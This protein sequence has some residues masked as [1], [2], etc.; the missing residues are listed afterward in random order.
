MGQSG[1]TPSKHPYA[2]RSQIVSPRL[3]DDVL[4]YIGPSLQKYK[5]CDILDLNPGAGLWSE[6]LHQFLKPRSHVLL[7]PLPE[8]F[9]EYLEPLVKKPGSKFRLV[10][11]DAS[12]FDGLEQ[13]LREGL[14]PHQNPLPAG[15]VPS[16]EP[17]TTLLVTGTIVWNPKHPGLNFFSMAGQM[18]HHFIRTSWVNEG[19]HVCGPVR[20]LLWVPSDDTKFA[21]NK[22]AMA[23]SRTSA[24]V[25]KVAAVS[26]VVK[27]GHAQDDRHWV[28]EAR[29]E[30]E[31]LVRAM[32]RMEKNGVA[33]PPHRRESIHAFADDIRK[34]T[35]DTGV[36][37]TGALN[38][39]LQAQEEAGVLTVGLVPEQIRKQ[40]LWEMEWKKRAPPP[41]PIDEPKKKGRRPVPEEQKRLARARASATRVL[42]VRT[43]LDEL[44]DF[45]Y[46]N[47]QLEL[48]IA[49]MED[50]PQKEA[51]NR[52]LDA[53]MADFHEKVRNTDAH[54]RPSIA[55]Q[56][57]ERLALRSPTPLLQWD[58]RA[59]EPLVM[60]PDEI[61]PICPVSLL[62]IQPNIRPAE[63]TDEEYE[64]LQD[65]ASGLLTRKSSPVGEAL[66]TLHPGASQL[67]DQ[68]PAIRDPKRGGRPRV[69]EM[70]ARMLT[71]EMIAGLS[72]A[73]RE[74]PFRNPD[75]NHPRYFRIRISGGSMVRDTI[76]SQ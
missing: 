19:Y 51:M 15:S 58:R 72:K 42:K 36:M 49:E 18:L 65:M 22:S 54:T 23:V 70:R 14:F 2:Y 21:L 43:A 33:M 64:Y 63:E 28:R 68:V 46:S 66:E 31:S 17:N 52:E 40:W 30:I 25:D 7:E 11:G 6:K 71:Q 16:R 45:G 41:P 34:M 38:D 69:E 73:F 37:S 62:D 59:Y 67:I 5:G 76:E 20:S 55:T 75:A 9:G 47:Y 35:N 10:Q 39:Y 29:Y 60:Q 24:M 44:V 57:D 8:V 3:C 48:K 4:D 61:Y 50:G 74:W 26:E 32:Q 56:L 27:P 12:Y 13:L 1:N 53:L